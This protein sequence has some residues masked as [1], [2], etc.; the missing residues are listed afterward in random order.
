MFKKSLGFTLIELLVVIA[1]IG[2]LAA[3]VLASLNDA[4]SS[5]TNASIEQTMNSTR[6]QAEIF[7]NAQSPNTYTGVCADAEIVRLLDAVNNT[8]VQ[9]TTVDATLGNAGDDV[10]VICHESADGLEFA[11]AAPF[12][13]GDT[14][15]YFCV[16]SSGNAGIETASLLANETV[17]P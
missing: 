7:Y 5:G 15:Q 13:L 6:S 1:I 17:C 4:R 11:T 10:T 3:V 9:I 16:D 2:I 8:S 12:L 14:Q